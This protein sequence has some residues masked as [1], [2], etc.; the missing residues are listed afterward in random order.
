MFLAISS[1]CQTNRSGTNFATQEEYR[2]TK[3]SVWIKTSN[4]LIFGILF[5][6]VRDQQ[7]LMPAVLCLQGGG[8]VGLDNYIYE[9]EFFAKNGVVALVCDKSGAGKS[10]TKKSWQQQSF[11]EKTTEYLEIHSWLTTQNK[12]DESRVGIHGMSEGGRLALNMA[13]REPERVAFLNL[14]SGPLISFKMNQLYAIGHHLSDQNLD[15]YEI[16]MA[17][18]VWNLYF[19]D[20]AGGKISNRTLKAIKSLRDELPGLRYRPAVSVNLPSRPLKEDIHFGLEGDID[21]IKAPILFQYGEN[22][23]LVNVSASISLIPEKANFL[24]KIY[25]ET[26]HSMNLSNGDIQPNYLTDKK[27]WLEH[28]LRNDNQ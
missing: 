6:P 23:K 24:I 22:D 21:C 17:I 27:I 9:A 26:D 4:G 28:M 2:I 14:V 7:D 1:S 12:V 10:K 15:V 20:V 19:D 5:Q 8:N 3:D 16:D 11:V 25:P 18:E 13:I